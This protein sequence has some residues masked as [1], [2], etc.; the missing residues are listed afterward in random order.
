MCRLYGKF[1]SYLRRVLCK[2]RLIFPRINGP[3]VFSESNLSSGSIKRRVDHNFFFSYSKK[4]SHYTA[5]RGKTDF[6]AFC[7]N[8]ATLWISLSESHRTNAE[9]L[10]TWRER[11][12]PDLSPLLFLG[13]WLEWFQSQSLFFMSWTRVT[14]KPVITITLGADLCKFLLSIIIFIV[15]FHFDRKPSTFQLSLN[16]TE[17]WIY[18]IGNILFVSSCDWEL[19]GCT[20]L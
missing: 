18:S 7:T 16:E 6:V 19:L 1:A 2:T 17:V 15:R 3:N 11:Y 8:C 14:V 10:R 9:K 5:S 20:A 13:S 12:I 4:P